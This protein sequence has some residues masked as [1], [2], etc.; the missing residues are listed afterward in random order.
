MAL[1]AACL[2]GLPI[3]PK[4]LQ[5]IALSGLA[6][7]T[8]GPKGGAYDIDL[9][10]H[11]GR[12][13]EVCIHIAAVESVCTRE[14]ITL[15]QVVVDGGAHD[16]IRRGGRRREHLGDQIGLAWITSLGEMHFVA[17]PVRLAFTT[18]ACLQVIGRRDADR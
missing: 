16:T 12:D 11:L 8:R 7:P 17:D 3:Q 15:G 18:V 13:Q 14:Q 10:V 2:L 5:V 4:S 9:M 1:G 6:L